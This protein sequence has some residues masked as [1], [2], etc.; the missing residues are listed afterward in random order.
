M[1]PDMSAQ[2]SEGAVDF[3]RLLANAQLASKDNGSTLDLSDKGIR[4]LPLE[5]LDLI[6][7]EVA[8]SVPLFRFPRTFY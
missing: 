5:M 4:E 6:K 2:N 8:R 1:S 3:G 7:D